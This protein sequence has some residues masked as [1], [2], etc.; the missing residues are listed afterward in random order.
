[1]TYVAI[2]RMCFTQQKQTNWNMSKVKAQTD[3]RAE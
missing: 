2:Q 3:K 1:M